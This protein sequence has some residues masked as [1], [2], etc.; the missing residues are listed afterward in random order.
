MFSFCWTAGGHHPQPAR[1]GDLWLV[2]YLLARV[3][4]FTL[5]EPDPFGASESSGRREDRDLPL[6][7]TCSALGDYADATAPGF[8][9]P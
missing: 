3:N 9:R 5:A 2:I 4:M 7:S 1:S 8:S 6:L